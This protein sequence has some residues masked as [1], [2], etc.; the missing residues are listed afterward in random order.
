MEQYF[1]FLNGGLHEILQHY[2]TNIYFHYLLF[3]QE[4]L[5]FAFSEISWEKLDLMLKYS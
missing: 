4:A 5:K 1:Y 2:K 3:I